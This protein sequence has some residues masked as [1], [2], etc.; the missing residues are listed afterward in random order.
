MR[1]KTNS[2][3]MV[4]FDQCCGLG[5]YSAGGW[6]MSRQTSLTLCFVSACGTPQT[7]S[8]YCSKC[9]LVLCR[10]PC[11]ENHQYLNVRASGRFKRVQNH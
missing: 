10:Y 6:E 11:F 1:P 9:R 5:Q 8:F 7:S 2:M 4:Y 3:K